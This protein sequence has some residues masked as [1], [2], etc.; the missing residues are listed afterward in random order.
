MYEAYRARYA[1]MLKTAG[2][3]MHPLEDALSQSVQEFQNRFH[4]AE[5]SAR[6][7]GRQMY[8]S[9][10]P[11]SMDQQISQLTQQCWDAWNNV[12][13]NMKER[14]ET[15]NVLAQQRARLRQQLVGYRVMLQRMMEDASAVPSRT[16]AI[17]MRKITEC[18]EAMEGVESRAQAA[19]VQA[20]GFL[21][22]LRKEP[23][24]FAKYSHDPLMGI[25]TYP[26]GFH[27]ALLGLT[28]GS[29]RFLMRKRGFTRHTLGQTSYY[30]HPGHLEDAV[31]VAFVHGIGVGL[32]VYMPLIDALLETGRPIFL[33]EIP[34]VSGFRPWQSTSS[35]LPPAVVCSTMTAM[36][37]THGHL[38]AAWMG[39]SYGTSWLSYL[40]KY[41]PHIVHSLVFL[42][43]ICFCLHVPKLT[44]SF[45]YMKNDM[46]T[47]AYIVRT[48]VMVNWTIQRAFPWA[49]IALFVEQIS[50]P[51]SIFLSEIDALVPVAKTREYLRSRGV[52][53]A[54]HDQAACDKDARLSCTIFRNQGHGD[55]TDYPQDTLPFILQGLR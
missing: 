16:M 39:H 17:L 26:L 53:V 33:P 54:Y 4:E 30:Y 50:V 22:K 19:F 1:Q 32:I 7:K 40:C 11:A 49:W 46:G 37:A 2:E 35:V 48:D 23:Q 42:D 3:Q 21:P 44:K 38:Q 31:P 8:Q 47:I 34:Y 12:T 6:E 18:H 10:V 14:L 13:H 36:L 24:R 25:A 41:A 9:L 29:L 15:A 55:W 43:P 27:L 28:D 20:T 45:V 5:E 51:C 52:P